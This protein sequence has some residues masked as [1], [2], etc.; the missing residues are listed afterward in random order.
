MLVLPRIRCLSAQLVR[1][2]GGVP[3][4]RRCFL[5]WCSPGGFL[6]DQNLPTLLLSAP[7]HGICMLLCTRDA[8]F[9]DLLLLWVKTRLPAAFANVRLWKA[10]SYSPL[11]IDMPSRGGHR[12]REV[13]ECLSPCVT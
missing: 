7:I 5:T 2:C 13:I 1:R 10:S 11:I 3:R 12:R 6:A 4:I 8:R 9:F